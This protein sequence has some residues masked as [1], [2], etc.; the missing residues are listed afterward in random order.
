MKI[1]NALAAF[2]AIKPVSA[3]TPLTCYMFI[4]PTE[5][6]VCVHPLVLASEMKGSCTSRLIT[7]F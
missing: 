5:E 3:F 2:A 7:H 1:I 6:A 4:P